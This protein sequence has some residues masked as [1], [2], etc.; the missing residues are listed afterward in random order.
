MRVG[1]DIRDAIAALDAE[2]L[3]RL[4]PLVASDEDVFIRQANSSID[5]GFPRS[6]QAPRSSC[7]LQGREGVSIRP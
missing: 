1:R 3:Q 7:E 2:L 4:R 5:N 6:I